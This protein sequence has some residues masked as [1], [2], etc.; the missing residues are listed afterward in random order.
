MWRSTPVTSFDA[1]YVYENKLD[2]MRFR[3]AWHAWLTAWIET[4]R[5]G[6]VGPSY[7]T[8]SHLTT[9]Q[10][11][12]GLGGFAAALLVLFAAAARAGIVA[13]HF[14]ARSH[15]LRRFGLRGAGLILQL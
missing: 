15:R 14:G 9:G 3:M 12:A 13:A 7:L 4:I 1:L 11:P 2:A 6:K 5:Y 8:A 10:R